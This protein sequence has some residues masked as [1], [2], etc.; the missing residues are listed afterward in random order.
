MTLTPS[1]DQPSVGARQRARRETLAI[2]GCFESSPFPR[3]PFGR[4]IGITFRLG[5]GNHQ[6]QV[7]LGLRAAVDCIARGPNAFIP[8]VETS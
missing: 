7:P 6:T 1:P 8:F 4:K 3:L 5:H 2:F